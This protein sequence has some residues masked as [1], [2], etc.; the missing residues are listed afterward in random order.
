MN[1]YTDELENAVRERRKRVGTDSVQLD[2]A[3]ALDAVRRTFLWINKNG[4]HS[5]SFIGF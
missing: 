1:F 4:K 3:A 5:N 2:H